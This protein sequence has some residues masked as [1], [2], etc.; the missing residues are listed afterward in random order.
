MVRLYA[1]IHTALQELEAVALMLHKMAFQLSG[2]EVA[3]YLDS[4]I[5]N[6]YYVI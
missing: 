2:N 4:S 3:L 5:V 1:K 6:A